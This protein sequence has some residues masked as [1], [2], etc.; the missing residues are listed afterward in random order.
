MVDLIIPLGIGSKSD[1]D[2]LKILLRSI[3][4]NGVGVRD[5]I[6]VTDA[7][8]PW[9]TGVRIVDQG[10]PLIRNKDGNILGKVLAA[11]TADGVTDEFAWSSDDCVLL[12]PFDFATVPPTWNHRGKE[13][14]PADGT[15][16]QR[17]VRRTFEM[18]ESRGVT[19]PHNYESHMPHRYPTR[20]VIRALRNVDFKS[21]IGYS[22]NTLL[23]GLLGITGGFDQ[24]IFKET[25]ERESGWRLEKTVVGYNDRA[26]LNGLREELFRRFP[27]KSKYER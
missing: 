17:R 19:L 2:E 27:G 7:P 9:L 15:I 8:P 24:K 11:I 12:K 4:K 26:F 18:L 16:W 20:K 21:D 1:N 5:V 23:H 10:D 6:V 22:I 13:D 25:C 3:E 14:F